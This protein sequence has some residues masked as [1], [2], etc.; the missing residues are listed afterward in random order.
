MVA[1]QAHSHRRFHMHVHGR[2]RSK[3]GGKVAVTGRPRQ[4]AHENKGA[5]GIVEV[6]AIKAHDQL[7]ASIVGKRQSM[8]I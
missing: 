1:G 2:I 7:P 5:S 3:E 4:V 6:S 8:N